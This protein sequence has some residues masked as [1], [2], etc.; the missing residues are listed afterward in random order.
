MKISKPIPI[1]RLLIC[2]VVALTMVSAI[3]CMGGLAQILYVIKGHKVPAEYEG[4]EGK[5]VAVV[6]VS[7]ASAYGPDTLTSTINKIVGIKLAGN[8]KKIDVI[9][10]GVIQ[11]WIDRNGW[12]ETDFVVLG[13]GVGAEKVLAIEIGNYSIHEGRTIY[14]GRVELK[15]TVFD[16]ENDGQVSYLRGPELF[17][18]PENGRPAIQTTDR[19]FEAIFLVQLTQSIARKFY[20]HDLLDTIAEDAR[21][22]D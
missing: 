18:Y 9:S 5:R 13:K 2:G 16:I 8:V 3:G 6:C 12:D 15:A 1:V 21:M 19:K 4:F 7:D 20:K 11:E 14:K 22:L 10:P 17:E